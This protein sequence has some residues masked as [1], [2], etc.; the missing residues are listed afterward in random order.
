MEVGYV[1]AHKTSDGWEYYR[2][3]SRGRDVKF[4]K[5]LV[6]AQI[7]RGYHAAEV[8]METFKLDT[9]RTSCEIKKIEIK[10]IENDKK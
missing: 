1:I 10:L 5:K 7:Y 2:G 3:C 8:A 6:G 4:A 9:Y